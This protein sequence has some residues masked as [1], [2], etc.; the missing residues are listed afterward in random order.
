MIIETHSFLKYQREEFPTI[1]RLT[2]FCFHFHLQ[3]NLG[4]VCSFSV[5]GRNCVIQESWHCVTCGIT[6]SDGVCKSC[7]RVCHKD[8]QVEK[9]PTVANF[10]DC[11]TRTRK[12][13]T[14]VYLY[15]SLK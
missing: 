2:N 15:D 7:M 13:E 4:K 10:C 12:C 3:E 1:F 8:H 14:L 9:K 11:S 5:T 6:G